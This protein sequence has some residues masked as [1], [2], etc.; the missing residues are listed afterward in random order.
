M[1]DVHATEMST[2]IAAT[3]YDM[4]V[5]ENVSQSAFLTKFAVTLYQVSKIRRICVKLP[6]YLGEVL[7][8]R[9]LCQRLVRVQEGTR[10]A[11]LARA[12]TVEFA[13][14]MRCVCPR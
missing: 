4:A 11:G 5:G 13:G 14:H 7:A 9:A 3:V 1:L 8:G 2:S 12:L 6:A 10:S